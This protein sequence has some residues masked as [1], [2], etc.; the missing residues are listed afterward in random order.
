MHIFGSYFNLLL[1]PFTNNVYMSSRCG[2]QEWFDGTSCVSF[3]CNDPHCVTCSNL[4]NVCTT[5]TANYNVASDG[6][7]SYTSNTTSTSNST[8]NANQTNANTTNSTSVNNLTNLS[9]SNSTLPIPYNP[10]SNIA[11]FN[12]FI[13]FL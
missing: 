2:P 11:S 4:P 9:A 3:T 6:S 5:C 8:N 13:G 7:C 12:M 1:I 10:F